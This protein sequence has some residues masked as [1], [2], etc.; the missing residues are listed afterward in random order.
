MTRIEELL[1]QLCASGSV[2]YTEELPPS[3]LLFFDQKKCEKFVESTLQEI[4]SIHAQ[5]LCL[6]ESRG[7]KKGM[8]R[9]ADIAK[10]VGCEPCGDII[11]QAIR[12]Q[13]ESDP[14]TPVDEGNEQTIDRIMSLVKRWGEF[15]APEI[16][17]LR[18]AWLDALSAKDEIIKELREKLSNS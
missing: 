1:Y 11:A 16:E 5:A 15:T 4:E 6:S 17:V 2:C 12:I 9:A 8:M 13:A 18:T 14:P 7:V 3:Q 10:K